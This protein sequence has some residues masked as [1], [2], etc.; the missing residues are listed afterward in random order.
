MHNFAEEIK[1]SFCFEFGKFGNLKLN[2]S[3][4]FESLSS[5]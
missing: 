1:A 2:E 3:A 4:E 5:S